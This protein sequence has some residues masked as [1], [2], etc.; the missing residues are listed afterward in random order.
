VLGGAYLMVLLDIG[1]LNVSLP[2]IQRQFDMSAP[3][4]QWIVSAYTLAFG[5]FLLLGGRLG[6]SIGRRRAFA[7]G[8]LLFTLSSLLCGLA[9]AGGALIAFRSVQGVAAAVVTPTVFSITSATFEQ[10][11][12]RHKALA[13][14]GGLGGLGIVLGVVLGGVITEYAGWRWIFLVNV[15]IGAFLLLLARRYLAATAAVARETRYDVAGAVTITAALIALVFGLTRS[16]SVGWSSAQVLVSLAAFVVLLALF[17]VIELRSDAPL[18]PLG[19]FRMPSVT[20]ANLFAFANGI[21]GPSTF[22]VLSLYLQQ[23]LGYSALQTG[24]GYLPNATC[25][26]LS[27]IVAQRLVKRVRVRTLIAAGRLLICGA[28]VYFAL[29]QP[30]G[31]YLTDVFPG[32]FLIGGGIGLAVVATSFAA[33]GAVEPRLSGVASG[34]LTT[35]Q[36]IGGAVGIALVVT[37]A[38]HRTASEL[39]NGAGDAAAVTAGY[40]LAFGVAAAIA[41]LSLLALLLLREP[42][43][44]TDPAPAAA[45]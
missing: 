29:I 25:L 1:I 4:L 17:V 31:S 39:A 35:S 2:S 37:V 6:D 21:S 13:V 27:S 18:V 7:G 33:L 41:S 38:A 8:L 12:E 3:T 15:P 14:L 43:T 24:I 10:G 9:W 42:R 16:T 34:L 26:V 22:L 30:D 40:R 28:L 44:A 20:G 32:L 45:S 5:G 11:E 36:Q 19:F 23:V